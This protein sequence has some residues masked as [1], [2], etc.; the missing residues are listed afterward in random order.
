[1]GKATLKK[2]KKILKLKK[3][4][5][6][7]IKN[8]VENISKSEWDEWNFRQKNFF[9]HKDTKSYPLIWSDSDIINNNLNIYKKC[10]KSDIIDIIADEL[11][12]LCNTYK[13]RIIKCVFAKLPPKGQIT[14]HWD[15]GDSLI[16][17][18]RLHLPIKTNS[19]VDFY[20]ENKLFNLK[21]S[22]WYEINN[23]K[24]HSVINK[25]SEDRI[26]L[27]VDVLPDYLNI[28]TSNFCD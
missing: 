10:L 21:E 20:I 16:Y 1:M 19:E 7:K 8:F 11:D 24:V 2:P 4:D 22:I 28:M 3:T 6:E 12:F 27:I 26:H 9:V 17:S 18:H 14:E 15:S 23:Q 13:G 5:I 25:S